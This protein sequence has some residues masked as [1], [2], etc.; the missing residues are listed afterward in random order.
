MEQ[1][2]A[3]AKQ[4]QSTLEI[5]APLITANIPSRMTGQILHFY[6]DLRNRAYRSLNLSWSGHV[7]MSKA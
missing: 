6:L 2:V 1:G 5:L 3:D 7:V 4:S